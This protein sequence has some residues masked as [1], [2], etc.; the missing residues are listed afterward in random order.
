MTSDM[1]H[2]GGVGA[3][4]TL[5]LTSR[6]TPPLPPDPATPGLPSGAQA[7]AMR[8]GPPPVGHEVFPPARAEWSPRSSLS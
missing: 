1:R 3:A 6:C 5:A 8:D 2:R 4:M 7:D